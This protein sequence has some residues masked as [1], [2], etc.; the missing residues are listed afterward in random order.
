MTDPNRSALPLAGITVVE[1]G[2]SIAGPYAARILSDMGA[3]VFKVEHPEGGDASRG[4]GVRT[5]NGTTAAYQCMNRGKFSITVD[6][7]NPDEVEHL[8]QF[9][10]ERVD[11]VVQN[12]RPGS[13]AGFGLG[14]E[15][16]LEL[17]PSL[18]YCD[19]GSFGARGPLAHLPGY[20]P[21]MQGFAGIAECNGEADGGPSRV[22]P[23]IIDL[24][25]GMWSAMGILGA[26]HKRNT[27]GQGGRVQTSLYE[28]AVGFMTLQTSLYQATGELPQRNGL[29]GPMIAPN[30]GYECADGL[31]I[32]VCATERQTQRLCDV[33]GA[34]EILANPKF[35][36]APLRNQHH[37]EF[38]GALNAVLRQY[39]RAHWAEKLDR[40]NIPNSPVHQLPEMMAHE[41]TKA[42]G[43][44]QPSPDGSFAV[45]A[46][47]VQFDGQ[48]AEFDRYAPELG[49]DNARAFGEASG[50][51]ESG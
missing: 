25:T 15:A 13:A 32:I 10:L 14:S 19:Q 23:P 11:I 18:I 46:L 48:R 33:I 37:D 22:L 8:R 5:L 4:W 35:A 42:T 41:Q 20:D 50:P 30:S 34:P 29:Q 38:A 12:L 1:M 39:T 45:V 36:T 28:T 40:A 2:S 44:L 27:T 21:L 16:L 24:G 49:E 51:A 17:K 9:I 47:P 43:M 3:E 26:L 7:R 6:M 31:L